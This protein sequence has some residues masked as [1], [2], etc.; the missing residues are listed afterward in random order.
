MERI[1]SV[2]QAPPFAGLVSHVAR[3]IVV[4]SL[5]DPSPLALPLKTAQAIEE[6][7]LK[8]APL[9][10]AVD[11]APKLAPPSKG[12]VIQRSDQPTDVPPK[13]IARGDSRESTRWIV[14]L[15]EKRFAVSIPNRGN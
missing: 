3:R 6:I 5:A 13:R 14:R 11:L 15:G 1:V 2:I 10:L 4:Q 7:V 12:I 9:R 8:L